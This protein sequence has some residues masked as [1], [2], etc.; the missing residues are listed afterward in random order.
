M[1]RWEIPLEQEQFLPRPSRIDLVVTHR[2]P[3]NIVSGP[4]CTKGFLNG[5][6]VCEGCCPLKAVF[7]STWSRGRAPVKIAQDVGKCAPSLETVTPPLQAVE[8]LL[9]NLSLNSYPVFERV[10]GCRGYFSCGPVMTR[11]R[12]VPPAAGDCANGR[13]E[14]AGRRLAQ[15]GWSLSRES[16]SFDF[17]LAALDRLI[18]V[19]SFR[20]F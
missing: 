8:I 10:P 17:W 7:L 18:G 15:T 5:C 4:V 9:A 11:G 1:T 19:S 12:L 16:L 13:P 2:I 6:L 3:P 20:F 14:V